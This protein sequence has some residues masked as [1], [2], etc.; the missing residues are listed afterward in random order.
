MLAALLTAGITVQGQ[1]VTISWQNNA[2]T[3]TVSDDILSLV[4]VK[5]SEYTTEPTLLCTTRGIYIQN[6]K[7]I[8]IR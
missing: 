4:K 6:G 5:V 1:E 7:T 2:A 8:V 3:V